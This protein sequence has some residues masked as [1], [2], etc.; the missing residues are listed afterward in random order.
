MKQIDHEAMMK[1]F[2]WEDDLLAKPLSQLSLRELRCVRDILDRTIKEHQDSSE[3]IGKLGSVI[4]SQPKVEER[5]S[6]M[7]LLYN[8]SNMMEKK[9]KNYPEDLE[10]VRGLIK[11]YEIEGRD[12]DYTPLD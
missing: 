4:S 9:Q 2:K 12:D 5:E 7:E 3:S 10:I 8:V 1:R 11:R 6:L